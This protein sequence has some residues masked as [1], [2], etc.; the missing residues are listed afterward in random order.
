MIVAQLKTGNKAV[1]A[2]SAW[3]ADRQIGDR[4]DLNDAPEVCRPAR[5]SESP[6]AGQP[7]VVAGAALS[8][9]ASTSVKLSH[10]ATLK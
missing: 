1:A 7:G 2:A 6:P 5:S 10:T 4:I 8:L 9:G 3:L